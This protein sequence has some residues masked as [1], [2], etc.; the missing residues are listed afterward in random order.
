MKIYVVAH[1]N[2]IIPEEYSK[3]EIEKEEVVHYIKKS[4]AYQ[5]ML[6]NLEDIVSN[7]PMDEEEYVAY[8]VNNWL[9]K[10]EEEFYEIGYY[11]LGD[12]YLALER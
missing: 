9:T 7:A 6:E 10:Q 4:V 8:L 5:D 12:F 2:I 11:D 1:E 3:V